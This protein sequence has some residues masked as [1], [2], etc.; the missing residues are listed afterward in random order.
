MRTTV[1]ESLITY[2]QAG[3]RSVE[4][5]TSQHRRSVVQFDDA[6]AMTNV[7]TLAELQALEN[8]F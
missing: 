4:H 5:W 6:R 3:S 1:K 8:K 7:N 2:L